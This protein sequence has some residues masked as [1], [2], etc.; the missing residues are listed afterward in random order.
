MFVA[1]KW[2]VCEES[3]R[4]TAAIR[5]AFSRWSK[6]QI[7]PRLY[8]ARTVGEL[9]THLDEA[10][11]DL[12]LVEVGQQNLSEVLQL[13]AHRGSHS[14][15]L[16]ALLDNVVPHGHTG[17]AISGEPS[18]QA[19]ADLLWEAGA[20]EIIATPRQTC[21]LLALHN[22]LVVARGSIPV[23][24]VESRSFAEWAWSTLPW[25]DS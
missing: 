4:W 2:V 7:A 5:V 15:R 23:D 20:V 24:S 19:V 6:V 22:R 17:T 13:M 1:Q 3:G 18:T 25:Q 21:G 11:C 9:S 10:G 12:A 16:V 14:P 8:E